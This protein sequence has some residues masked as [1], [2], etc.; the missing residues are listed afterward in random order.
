MIKAEKKYGQNFLI[1]TSV[2]DRIID[3]IRVTTDDLIIEI[4]PG[5][6]N[7]SRKLKSTGANILAFEID[8]RMKDY[9]N[10][11]EDDRFKVIY[12]DILNIDLEKVISNIS[13]NRIYV[14]ANLPYYITTPIVNKLLSTK[15]DISEMR[16][17]VQNEVAD[18]FSATSGHKE[19]GM[20]TVL[21]NLKYDVNKLFI[22]DRSCFKPAPNVD[23]AIVGLSLKKK[24]YNL[25]YEK[26]YN[27]L[28]VAFSH[29]RKTLKNN[30]GNELW[31]KLYPTIKNLGYS[32]QVRAEEINVEDYICLSNI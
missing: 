31:E 26:L 18:R 15:I 10:V 20:M 5:T 23:S 8:T 30:I 32:D 11:I 17:M 24:K 19:Y 3:S 14:I 13:Y 21:L 1:D 16:L 7:L 27:F 22:V 4:G 28:S 6:G 2:I 25:D 9:L 29:K 12:E